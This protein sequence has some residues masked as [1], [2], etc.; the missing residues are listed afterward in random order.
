MIR[1]VWLLSMC[2]LVF[3]CLAQEGGAPAS[4]EFEFFPQDPASSD[5]E[6]ASSDSEAAAPA[7]DPLADWKADPIGKFR[8]LVT[9]KDQAGELTRLLL[10]VIGFIA[11]MGLLGA[12][13]LSL[14][15]GIFY[16]ILYRMV[17]KEYLGFIRAYSLAFAC[18]IADLVLFIGGFI[19]AVFM[20]QRLDDGAPYL[21]VPVA[22]YFLSFFVHVVILRLFA[23]I[24]WKQGLVIEFARCMTSTT[25]M[26]TT[27]G[28]S[29]FSSFIG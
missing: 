13:F 21:W 2:M 6:T 8:E 18:E 4:T 1:W 19:A 26:A 14:I 23:K 15:I 27:C 10:L 7:V 11:L 16:A 20:S 3:P 12:L 28:N 22:I 24:T 29:E 9:A 25:I 17:T 5:S